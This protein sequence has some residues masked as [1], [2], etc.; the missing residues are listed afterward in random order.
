MPLHRLLITLHKS[1]ALNAYYKT[2]GVFY[3]YKE[4]DIY[5]LLALVGLS[6]Y[7]F[8]GKIFVSRVIDM[9]GDNN[10]THRFTYFLSKYP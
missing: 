3:D 5:F 7:K 10:L 1:P 6:L 2:I 9:G 8:C 4:A